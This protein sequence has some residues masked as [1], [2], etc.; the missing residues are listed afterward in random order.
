MKNPSKAIPSTA[1][2]FDQV[3]SLLNLKSDRSLAERLKQSATLI[4]RM[5]SGRRPLNPQTIVN[6]HEETQL[7]IYAVRLLAGTSQL[8]GPSKPSKEPPEEFCDFI[9]KSPNYELIASAGFCFCIETKELILNDSYLEDTEDNIE[10]YHL[11]AI[12]QCKGYCPTAGE[13]YPA[14]EFELEEMKELGIE[15]STMHW[16]GFPDFYYHHCSLNTINDLA[17]VTAQMIA[18]CPNFYAIK[19]E[20]EGDLIAAMIAQQPTQP[21]TTTQRGRL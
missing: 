7:P 15:V 6:I 19:A 2:L 3:K 20:H 14:T 18:E 1:F 11:V 5:R 4:C 16:L 10:E 13:F 17:A 8:Q 12:A 9:R 21:T